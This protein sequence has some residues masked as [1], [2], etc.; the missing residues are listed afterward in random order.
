M[1]IHQLIPAVAVKISSAVY[2]HGNPRYDP[3]DRG[4]PF[5]HMLDE[6]RR[7]FWRHG[8]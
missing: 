6:E 8:V 2:P 5:S 7:H 3:N 4:A 1:V